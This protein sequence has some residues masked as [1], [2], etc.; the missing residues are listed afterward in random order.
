MFNH[1]GKTRLYLF[2]TFFILVQVFFLLFSESTFGYGGLENIFQYRN[3][4]FLPERP[5]ILFGSNPFYSLLLAPFSQFGYL[6][7]K[8]FNIMLAT[9]TLLL[10]TRIVTRLYSGGELFALILI[11]FSPVF[12]QLS[13]SCLPEILFG[14]LLTAAIYLFIS[15]RVFYSTLVISFIPFVFPGGFLIL[16]VFAATFILAR[17]Y[18]SIPLLLS[19]TVLYSLAGWIATGEFFW[20]FQIIQENSAESQSFLQFI[21]TIPFA[22]GIPLTILAIA[23]LICLGFETLKKF[24]F[25]NETIHHILIS[26]SWITWFVFI[27][28]ESSISGGFETSSGVVVPLL[29]I[30]GMKLLNELPKNLKTKHF[31][32]VVFSVFALLQVIQLYAWNNLLIKPSPE[33]QLMEKTA[34]YLR[35]NEPDSKLIYFNPLLAHFLELDPYKEPVA[36]K[37]FPGSQQPSVNMDWGDFL[38]W[39]SW[40]S[41]EEE[42]LKLENT[43]SDPYLKKIM[44]FTIGLES[45]SNPNGYSV[46]IFKKAEDKEDFKEISNQYKSVLS[47]EK[48]LDERVK[49]VDGIKVWELDSTQDYSPSI[50]FSPEVVFR[51]EFYEISATLHYQVLQPIGAAEVLLVFS[52]E[53]E[54]N[55]LHYKKAD[56]I[57]ESENWEKLDLHVEIP[58]DI[59]ETTQFL[60]YIWN[61][62]RKNMLI[63]KIEVEVKSF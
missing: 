47:F 52:A 20:Y 34:A 17:R 15:Y 61:K 62:E 58:S 22:L 57:S 24:S 42:G 5:E 36:E 32:F 53:H 39:D 21:Q 60:V 45:E 31:T 2:F 19:G 33:E 14:F 35:F 6:P 7:A 44:S 40:Y 48:Y 11:S 10:S 55:N 25:R 56:I 37:F 59:P 13:A 16:F 23:G 41:P 38:V 63:E 27:F 8:G 9:F 28:R 30:T 1:E 18:L 50:R 12:F 49:E 43:E 26:G 29:A 3:A 54:G 46:Q 51:Q 4:R